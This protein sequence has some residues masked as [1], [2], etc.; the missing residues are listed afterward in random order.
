MALLDN[1]PNMGFIYIQNLVITYD[2]KAYVI[3]NIYTDKKYIY[4]DLSNPS[5]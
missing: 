5:K 3:N 2:N 1:I 4:W